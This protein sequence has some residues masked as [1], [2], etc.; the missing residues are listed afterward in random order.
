MDIH[1]SIHVCFWI[2]C[3]QDKT[4]WRFWTPYTTPHPA[5][6]SSAGSQVQCYHVH[7]IVASGHAKELSILALPLLRIICLSA[8]LQLP[9]C[10][11]V[12]VFAQVW[13]APMRSLRGSLLVCVVRRVR[14]G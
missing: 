11:C 1:P 13:H 14:G 12:C 8:C 5:D 9:A 10:V 7:T 6:D 4:G 3:L 2:C